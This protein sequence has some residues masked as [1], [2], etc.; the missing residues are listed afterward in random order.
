MYEILNGAFTATAATSPSCTS[1]TR[2][3]RSTHRMIVVSAAVATATATPRAIRACG[4]GRV[5]AGGEALWTR[6][7][8]GSIDVAPKCVRNY[9]LVDGY[10][11][12]SALLW[13]VVKNVIGKLN[14]P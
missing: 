2:G 8:T 5:A 14:N 13:L 11:R 4:A 10:G 9:R 7:G 1:L 3:R 6:C 12:L